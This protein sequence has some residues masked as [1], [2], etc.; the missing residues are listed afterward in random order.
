MLSQDQR[1]TFYLSTQDPALGI[2]AYVNAVCPPYPRPINQ[3][4]IDEEEG[5]DHFDD[6]PTSIKA[7]FPIVI[8]EV[9]GYVEDLYDIWAGRDTQDRDGVVFD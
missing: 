3:D 7:H 4:E 2:A 8:P 9:Y 5:Y 1:N 6:A